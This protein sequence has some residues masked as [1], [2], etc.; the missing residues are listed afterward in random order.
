MGQEHWLSERQLP[1]LQKLNAQFVARSGMEEAISTGIHKGRPFG[2]VCISWSSDLNHVVSPLTK[3]K[4]KRIV[5]AELRANTSHILFIC[6][7]MPFYKSS[8]RNSCLAETKDTISMIDK[9][10]HDHPGHLI[11]IGGDLN[12]ELKG[13]S[14]FDSFWNDLTEKNQLSYCTDLFPSPGYTY[15][16]VA[17]GH[18]KQNDHFI[19]SKDILDNH[20]TKG[21]KVLDEGHNVSD[22]LP[23]LMSIAIP[24][25]LPIKTE[26]RDSASTTT[27]KWSKLMAADK[28]KYTERLSQLV[29]GLDGRRSSECPGGCH[30]DDETCRYFIQQEYDDIISCMKEASSEL[31]RQKPGLEKEWWTPGLTALKNRSIEIHRIWEAEGQP[32]SGHTFNEKLRV[33]TAYKQEIRNAQRAP[34]LTAWNRL[35]SSMES[36]DTSGFWNSWRKL[37]SQNKSQFAPVVDGCSGK[38]DIA[39]TFKR[40]FEA[41]SVPNNAINVG[42]LNERYRQKYAEYS[43]HHSTNCKC[44]D[45]TISLKN[46]ID[47]ILSMEDGKCADENELYAEHFHHAPLNVLVKLTHVFNRM[48]SHSFVPNQ[49]KLGFMIPIV[50]DSQ[51][52]HSEVSNYRGITISPLASKV[53]EHVLKAIFSDYLSTSMYQFGYKKKSSTTH[54]IYCL[55]QT[56]NYYSNHGSNVYCSFLDASKAFDRLVHSGLFLKL[57]D[58]KVPK[59]FL[60]IIISWYDGLWCRVKWDNHY[61][62][63]FQISAGVRQREF[64]LQTSTPSM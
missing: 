42:K 2:G 15:H 62:E 4:H 32:R 44:A 55:K 28:L 9:I 59:I 50:K 34:K 16:H 39:E 33:R 21:H 1:L 54:A 38:D 40:S 18:R 30:C 25:I 63:W 43:S 52:N 13:K 27:L 46:V 3:Y 49:F 5:A 10:I 8:K 45:Y 26:I 57:M 47:A 37:Y 31:P 20:M 48:M 24:S 35:H 11:V 56:I 64:F 58:R 61:S 22:H 53:F 7:Y 51:G 29:A 36:N 17:L 23:I 60:D 14:P 12:T 19:V 41:N 6:V